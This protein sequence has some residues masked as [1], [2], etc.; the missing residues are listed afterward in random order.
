MKMRSIAG[1]AAALLASCWGNWAHAQ[2]ADTPASTAPY[3]LFGDWLQSVAG[4]RAFGYLQV[5]FSHNNTSS[6]DQAAGGHSNFPVIGASD[7]GLQLN[8]LHFAFERPITTNILP[9]I[10]PIPGPIPWEYSWGFNTELIYGRNAL[11]AGMLGLDADWGV[12]RTPAGVVPGSNRQNYVAMPQI[13]AQFYM[14]WGDGMALTVGRFGAGVGRDIP[15]PWRPGPS[16]FYTHTYAFG[17]QPDQVAGALFSA[18]LMR[19]DL[20]FLA[21]EIGVVQGRQ[22]WKDNNK[23]KSLIGALRWRSPDMNTWVDYSFMR[24]NE[25][26]DVTVNAEIQMPVARL[27]SPRGQLREHHSV[28]L[29][30]KPADAW[31]VNAEILY[32]NQHGDGQPGTID[33]LT[34]NPAVGNFFGGGKY[35]GLN[36]QAVYSASRQLRYAVRAETFRDRSGV[37][38]F[39]VT[40]VPSDFNAVTAGL[41]Y[42]LNKN[43]ILR[44]EIRHDWQS[45]HNGINAFGG[46]TA[47]KQTT[48]SVD[49]VAYF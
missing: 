17:S 27:I 44:P 34:F 18:N 15:P 10:T 3:S 11:P 25:Q 4:I 8:A 35:A 2:D 43:V 9:R 37:A 21:G 22:N 29:A 23:D 16:V 12:N 36:A 6:H 31:Q 39:P 33:V 49:L 7:E 41:A 28:S 47:R 32:G 24:G 5:G 19:N 26:N 45:H 14:P 42:E 30:F 13:F 46:G 20:G 1:A 48:L 40:A 38:L